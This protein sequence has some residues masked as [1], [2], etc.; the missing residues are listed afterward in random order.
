MVMVPVRVNHDDCYYM[1]LNVMQTS[2]GETVD[3]PHVWLEVPE[4]AVID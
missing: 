1:L 3:V 4:A 2:N